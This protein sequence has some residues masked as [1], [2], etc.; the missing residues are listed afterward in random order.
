M[1]EFGGE[2]T[3][4]KIMVKGKITRDGL[5]SEQI[6]GPIKSYTCAC[7]NFTESGKILYENEVCP[8]CGVKCI[9]NDARLKTFGKINLLFPVIKPIKRKQF[10]NILG[11][12]SKY[13]LDPKKADVAVSLSRYLVIKNNNQELTLVNDYYEIVNNNGKRNGDIIIPLRITGLYSFIFALRFAAEKLNNVLAKSLFDNNYIMRILKV[14]PPDVR[15]IVRDPKNPNEWRVAEVNKYYVRILQ[16]NNIMGIR[17][18]LPDEEENWM[19][20]IE[21]NI[22]NQICDEIVDEMIIEYDKITAKFQYYVD[23]IYECV[24]DSISGKYGFIRQSILGKTIEFSA[25]AVL[26]TNPALQPYEVGVSKKILY[27]LWFPYFLYYLK[28]TYKNYTFTDLYNKFVVSNYESSK[29][30]FD[31]FLDWFMKPDEQ[32]TEEKPEIVVKKSKIIRDE[33][34]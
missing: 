26:T 27:R 7:G 14:L 1:P 20:L 12:D 10:N 9:S 25:R 23:K 33:E 8:K 34:E 31:E 21:Y 4:P 28:M 18:I 19:K 2:V 6:F 3:N 22:T 32:I 17:D 15:P 30:Y 29:Q 11:S 16:L 5:L 24:F 13:L